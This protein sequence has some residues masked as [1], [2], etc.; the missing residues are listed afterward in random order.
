MSVA[1]CELRAFVTVVALAAAT[2]ALADPHP[3]M[4]SHVPRQADQAHFVANLPA[5]QMMRLAI[6]LP[7]HHEPMLDALLRDLQDPR[8]PD[9]HRF[10]SVSDFTNRFGP[11]QAEYAA[12]RGFAAAH[13]LQVRATAPNRFVLDVQAPAAT[14]EQAFGIHLGLYR[15]ADGRVF[16][17][18]DREPTMDV[19]MPVLHISGLDN[20]APP[21][22]RSPR[23]AHPERIVQAPGIGAAGS[24][25]GG[26]YTATD[27][28][29][30]YYGNGSLTGAG[31]IVG[32]V[33]FGGYNIA[34]IQ[35]YFS[36]LGQ[37]LKV[38]VVGISVDGISLTCTGTCDDYEQAIDVEQTI[39]MAPGLQQV[40]FYAGN[41]VIDIL[42]RIATDNT[43]KQISSS[44][45]WPADAANED[46]VYKEYAAQGQTFVDGSGDDGYELQ[47]GGVWPADDANV[48]GV[49]GTDLTTQS[50]GA[51]QSEVAWSGSGGGPSPDGIRIPNW[52]KPFVNANN[53]ASPKWRNVPDV[54]AEADYD[55]WACYDLTC[56]GGNGGTSFS[57]PRW[58]GFMALINQQS[59]AK[60]KTTVGFLNPI[61]YRIAAGKS[62]DSDFHDITSGNNG[63]Y[64]AV[65]G[66]DDATGLGSPQA[67]LIN[68][69]VAR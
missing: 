1:R 14:V 42:N 43:A 18:P 48:T 41:T 28:R 51:W 40:S 54:A 7:L 47:Q 60:K 58:A 24:G 45:G 6:T 61:L 12:L 69:V 37:S 67:A 36:G 4:T 46:P 22:A 32:L 55:S 27:I 2:G 35:S 8:S 16:F 29:V 56:N 21:A 10:L 19:P 5:S 44:Y 17:A 11:T 64:S 63:K 26:N 52:Q 38:P 39:G 25:P 33:E 15:H 57:A 50:G 68:A 20:A 59:I 62:Y 23:G 66:Y 9:F 65:V 3:L 30:A 31:Q 13:G 53:N 34:D 49:G